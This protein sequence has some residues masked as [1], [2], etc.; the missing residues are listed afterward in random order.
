MNQGFLVFHIQSVRD[1]GNKFNEL[2]SV[3]WQTLAQ[4]GNIQT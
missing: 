2:G 3:A 4:A 1:Y